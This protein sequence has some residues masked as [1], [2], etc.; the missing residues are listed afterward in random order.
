MQDYGHEGFVIEKRKKKP[1]VN[2]VLPNLKPIDIY[3]DKKEKEKEK[4]KK[5][6]KE[7]FVMKRQG[8]QL[9]IIQE[10]KGKSNVYA[11]TKG[12]YLDT[13]FFK[14]FKI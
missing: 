1:N 11:L 7:P 3:G 10:K 4:E 2:N 12:S 6:K 8:S 13:D 9:S 5:V 14:A